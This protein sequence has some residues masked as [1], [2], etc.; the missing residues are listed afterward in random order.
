MSTS[1]ATTVMLLAVSFYLIVTTLPVTICY[2]LYL[3][4][5]AGSTAIT[6]E[7]V[8]S[9]P[10]WQR[11]FS[12]ISVKTVVQEVGMSHYACNVIIYML[13]G[14]MF[15]RELRRLFSRVLLQQQHSL[16]RQRHHGDAGYNVSRHSQSVKSSLSLGGSSDRTCTLSLIHSPSSNSEYV[17]II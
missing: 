10:T 2:V 3:T 11:Y 15:R 8:A 6:A 1:S 17:S 5:P 13:T 7:Q 4:F 16:S 12:Y 14:R 9:D